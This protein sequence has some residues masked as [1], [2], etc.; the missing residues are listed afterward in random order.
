MSR[1]TVDRLERLERLMRRVQALAVEAHMA[2][3]EAALTHEEGRIIAINALS[4]IHNKIAEER[5]SAP[6][7]P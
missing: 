7:K 5:A 4:E 2:S 1:I 3:A 6:N